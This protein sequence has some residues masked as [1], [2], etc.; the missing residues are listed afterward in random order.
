[1]T[2]IPARTAT[3]I[4]IVSAE[5]VSAV[6]CMREHVIMRVKLVDTSSP[7]SQGLAANAFR[8]ECF[9]GNVFLY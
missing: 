8:E 9:A 3:A 6:Q 7:S 1:M 2:I 5:L 4:F